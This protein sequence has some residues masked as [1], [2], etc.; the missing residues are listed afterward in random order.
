M[1]PRLPVTLEPITKSRQETWRSARPTKPTTGQTP[2]PVCGCRQNDQGDGR[3]DGGS[4]SPASWSPFHPP[5]CSDCRI[6][7]TTLD[8]YLSA[9]PTPG[10]R[11]HERGLQP[12]SRLAPGARSITALLRMF[13]LHGIRSPT[14]QRWVTPLI[15]TR[16]GL[17]FAAFT[18]PTLNH[19]VRRHSNVKDL[20]RSDIITETN[21]I[22]LSP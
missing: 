6:T 11:N 10:S 2:S 16:T 1:K 15:V 7:K 22:P 8:H 5:P 14:M 21:P 17:C 4:K 20:Q 12:E 13:F 9:T 3:R 18:A 19:I